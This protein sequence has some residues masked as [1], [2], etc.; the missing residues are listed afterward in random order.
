MPEAAHCFGTD[1]RR[2]AIGA[3]SSSS[4]FVQLWFVELSSAT[5]RKGGRTS[6][7][8]GGGRRPKRFG[9]NA[10][11]LRNVRNSPCNQ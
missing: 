5:L 8:V 4:T 6:H 7:P 2:P 10:Q 9:S 3:E 11:R 1:P